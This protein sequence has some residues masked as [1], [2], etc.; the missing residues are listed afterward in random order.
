[1]FKAELSNGVMYEFNS[2]IL[3][4]HVATNYPL[5]GYLQKASK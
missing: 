5:L 3:I 1:M 4:F 2:F